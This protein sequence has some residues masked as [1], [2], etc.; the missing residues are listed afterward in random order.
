MLVLYCFRGKSGKVSFIEVLEIQLLLLFWSFPSIFGEQLSHVVFKLFESNPVDVQTINCWRIIWKKFSHHVY[1]PLYNQ[2]I[3]RRVDDKYSFFLT[4][5]NNERSRM[6][7]EGCFLISKL[8][9]S[10]TIA[11]SFCVAIARTVA[12]NEERFLKSKLWKF[13]LSDESTNYC[14]N[15]KSCPE[16]ELNSI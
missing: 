7:F 6:L 8:I 5:G 2:I 4:K 12:L 15:K 13:M 16:V 14:L 3:A 1:A 10:D 9:F 11:L